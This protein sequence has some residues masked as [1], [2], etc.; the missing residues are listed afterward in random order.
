VTIPG[1]RGIAWPRRVVALFEKK[2]KFSRQP[3]FI[4]MANILKQNIDEL[5]IDGKYVPE[6][7]KGTNL[8]VTSASF[9]PGN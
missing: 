7:L 3:F 8:N 6:A 5:E 1:G 9:S 2:K 4:S